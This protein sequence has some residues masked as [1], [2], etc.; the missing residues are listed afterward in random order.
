MLLEDSTLLRLGHGVH[1]VERSDTAV[2]FGLDAT[3]SG[4]IE[5]PVAPALARAFGNIAWPVDVRTLREVL[6][7]SCGTDETA[8]RTLID[9]LFTYRIL[10]P[11]TRPT[12]ALAGTTP[13]ARE[14]A[15]ILRASGITVR[16][17]TSS[18]TAAEFCAR[19]QREPL[20]LVDCTHEYFDIGPALVGH[21]HPLVPVISFD[22]RVIIGPVG[23]AAPCPMCTYMRLNDRDE[24]V[25]QV[26]GALAATARRMDPV[27]ATMGA[28]VTATVI[29]RL[30]GIADPPGIVPDAPPPGWAA[31]VDPFVGTPVAPFDVE[32][33]PQC[34]ACGS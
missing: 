16:V 29:R 19:H 25:H 3:R 2:Q 12:V 6:K 14:L 1:V 20:V 27:V 23:G 30:I 26:S 9:D 17:R 4:V 22:S 13:L 24:H 8:A 5:S 18:D 7:K 33:H 11:D 21:G 32:P 34:P 10:I 15:R 31:V 28:A